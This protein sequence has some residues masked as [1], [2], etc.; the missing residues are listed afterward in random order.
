MQTSSARR[1]APVGIVA[2][3]TAEAGQLG[4]AVRGD[5]ALRC[6]ADGTRLA[7]TGVGCEAAAEGAR[8][9]LAAGCRSLASW[10]L[11]GGLDPS[12][13]AGDIVLPVEVILDRGA[14]LATAH[15]WRDRVARS[16]HGAARP[17][18]CGKLLTSAR[19]LET[20]AAKSIAF[21][22]TGACA[23][24]MESFAVAEVAAAGGLPFIAVRAIVDTAADEV[25][26]ALAAAAD[27]A[28]ALPI[29]RILAR[30]A[31]RPAQ[32]GA[33][34]RLAARY[35]AAVRALRAVAATGALTAGDS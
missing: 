23:V 14:S 12:L 15:A 26:S 10:G 17:V 31:A 19:A 5:A 6:L 21:R 25:P 30:L 9:L 18:A 11:A 13:V 27:A 28:G 32:T 20:V 29:G 35:R 8:R 33:L 24:D 1:T 7:V 4:P 16:L 34:L 2:A 3:L 22:G